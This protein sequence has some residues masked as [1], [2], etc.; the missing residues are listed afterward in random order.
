MSVTD[1]DWFNFANGA[2][3]PA[4]APAPAAAE[5]PAPPATGA[6]A[7][8]GTADAPTPPAA[9]PTGG[10]AHT[11]IDPRRSGNAPNP[12]SPST[13][14][15]VKSGADAGEA[16]GLLWVRES[17]FMLKQWK[18]RFV[19]LARGR[20]HVYE[21]VPAM[22]M[23]QEPTSVIQL[24]PDT[25]LMPLKTGE[26]GGKRLHYREVA[27][28]VP[29]HQ[30]LFK[31]GCETMPGVSKWAKAI[32]VAL[33]NV[34]TKSAQR[35]ADA[36]TM[37]AVLH[38]TKASLKE[39]STTK[40]GTI[41]SRRASL[42]GESK[43]TVVTVETLNHERFTI[44]APPQYTLHDVCLELKRQVKLEY[45]G[46]FSVFLREHSEFSCL[47]EDMKASQADAAALSDSRALVYRRRICMDCSQPI[48]EEAA[49][50]TE[51]NQAAHK[52]LFGEAVHPVVSGHYLVSNDDAHRLAALHLLSEVGQY[53]EAGDQKAHIRTNLPHYVS[54]LCCL[55]RDTS[56]V[57]AAIHDVYVTLKMS[58]LEAQRVYLSFCQKLPEYGARF[59]VGKMFRNVSSRGEGT[60]NPARTPP[61][62]LH[63]TRRESGLDVL[64]GINPAGVHVRPAPPVH[65][66]RYKPLRGVDVLS[67]WYLHPTRHIEVW[68]TKNR[69]PV[70]TYRVR[71]AR[72]MDVQVHSPSYKEMAS[73]IHMYV[74][75]LLADREGRKAPPKRLPRTTLD[76]VRAE[77]AAKEAEEP[78]APNWVEI[79]DPLTGETC[80]WNQVTKVTVWTRPTLE[81]EEPTA[82]GGFRAK[83]DGAF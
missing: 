37:A 3:A 42:E 53:E 76:N 27:R 54:A 45:D 63:D 68:G 34:V 23:G 82:G 48:D 47:P 70:L 6:G 56:E 38:P 29:K 40:Q 66:Q 50:A 74:Y 73:V 2:P 46:D 30:R 11:R 60:G 28:T 22:R 5:P 72:V 14:R 1:D 8:S 18:S 36:A 13:P 81:V 25:E 62:W 24:T 59:F 32:R 61:S 9:T 79:K 80:W 43:E 20:L 51:I 52:L 31:F 15:Q 7:G 78:L 17:H 16:R 26:H 4:P 44:V 75:Q 55:D 57:V 39:S 58:A 77:A 21:S 71:E 10:R 12:D 69:R 67:P 64:L 49:T 83:K 35:A 41:F 19:V 33:Q 65:D